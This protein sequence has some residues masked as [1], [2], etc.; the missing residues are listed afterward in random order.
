[1]TSVEK[2][3]EKAVADESKVKFAEYQEAFKGYSAAPRSTEGD[4]EFVASFL[5]MLNVYGPDWARA[6]EY[7]PGGKA[8]LR[9][10]EKL[11]QGMR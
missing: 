3:F 8:D 2:E 9:R 1:M 7:V 10:F 5:A 11:T 6:L 4:A